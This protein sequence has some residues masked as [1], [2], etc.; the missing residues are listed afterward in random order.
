MNCDIQIEG[1]GRRPNRLWRAVCRTHRRFLGEFRV[2]PH[3][4]ACR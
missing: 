2:N 3:D 1:K 4:V